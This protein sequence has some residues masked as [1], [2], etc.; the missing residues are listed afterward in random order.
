VG[1]SDVFIFRMSQNQATTSVKDIERK[2]IDSSGICG[3]LYDGCRDYVQKMDHVSARKQSFKLSESPYCVIKNNCV[4]ADLNLLQFIGIQEELRIN[5]SLDITKRIGIASVMNHSRRID[6]CTRFLYYSWISQKEQLTDIAEHIQKLTESSNRIPNA[7]HVITAVNIG[8]DVIAVLQLPLETDITNEIDDILHKIRHV[9]L[10]DNES[11]LVFTPKETLALGKINDIAVYSNT[12]FL[13]GI[14]RVSDMLGQIDRIKKNFSHCHPV[15]YCLRQI[16]WLNCQ[17]T[18]TTVALTTLPL[19]LNQQIERYL[20]RFRTSMKYLQ[21]SFKNHLPT[22]ICG[23]LPEL[24]YNARKQWSNLKDEYIKEKRRVSELVIAVRNGRRDASMIYQELCGKEQII[25]Q[26]TIDQLIENVNDIEKKAQMDAHSRQQQFNYS[27]VPEQRYDENDTIKTTESVSQR[28]VQRDEVL[29]TNFVLNNNNHS[30]SNDFRQVLVDSHGNNPSEAASSTYPLPSLQD[31]MILPVSNIDDNKNERMQRT[32][33][34]LVVPQNP[35]LSKPSS[36]EN[37]QIINIL[38]LGETGVGKSTFINAFVN[39][40]N[41]DTLQQAQSNKPVVLIPV[42]FLMT[43][44]DNFEERT[45]N[46]GDV[47]NSNNEDFDHPGQSMT[48]HCKSYLFHLNDGN[49]LCIIDTPGFG[50]TR[51]LD[52]DDLNMQHTLEYVN[53]LTHLNAICFL[54]KPNSSRLNIFF[55]SCFIQLFDFLGPNAC[56]NL[57]FCFTNARSTFYAPGDTAPLIKA[58]IASLS[59]NEIIF[60]KENTFCFDSESFRYLVALQS[61]IPFSDDDKREYEMSWSTSVTESNRLIDYVRTKFVAH[62]MQGGWKST[63]HAQFQIVKMVRPILETVRNILRNTILWNMESP[64]KSIELCSIVIHRPATLCRLCNPNKI[65]I[66]NFWI[67][68]DYP[69]EF[70]NTCLTCSCAPNE[71]IQI[72]YLLDYKAVN[73]PLMHQ[74]SEMQEQL[75]PLCDASVAFAYFLIHVANCTKDNLFLVSLMR[76]IEE[77]KRICAQS[78]PNDLNLQLVKDLEEQKRKYEQRMN[79]MVSHQEHNNLTV[80]YEWIQKISR[81]STVQEQLA[82]IKKGQEIMMK[83]YELDPTQI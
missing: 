17:Y 77:E 56:K 49:K 83:Q 37:D 52:Q 8:I 61:Q 53:N 51:G 62:R 34:L 76:M 48:Q 44:G 78:T 15:N 33:S 7:T 75:S 69:H 29:D 70:Q 50:D 64:N 24:I 11:S 43:V 36:S 45:V 1:E 72:D 42:S 30:K 38:L 74:K 25:L 4:D 58:M 41:F 26:N 23:H 66:D 12:P 55:R 60:K 13:T 2:A 31:I 32:P 3:G 22:S 5:L 21:A 63:K 39:Y 80:I 16:K 18:P 28:N 27:K 19:E 10:N 6:K 47:D 82:V 20:I 9:L 79:D 67:I 57:T 59:M 46:F 71:H 68:K 40:L 81:I 35:V 54:L 14:T 73:D 65:V